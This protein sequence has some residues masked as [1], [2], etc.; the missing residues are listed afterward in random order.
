MRSPGPAGLLALQVAVKH[1]LLSLISAQPPAA[2]TYAAR[3]QLNMP[4]SRPAQHAQTPA[5]SR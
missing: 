2:A 5:Q 3:A 1:P 4:P